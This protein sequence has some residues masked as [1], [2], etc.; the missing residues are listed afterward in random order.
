MYLLFSYSASR[1]L[2]WELLW[3]RD[4]SWVFHY[5][6]SAHRPTRSGARQ[7]VLER[8]SNLT[9]SAGSR[10][11]FSALRVVQWPVLRCHTQYGQVPLHTLLFARL[12]VEILVT[13]RTALPGL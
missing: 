2:C 13:H 1:I 4:G 12:V 7:S 3:K 5:I 9:F 11:V 6:M 10:A 8:L